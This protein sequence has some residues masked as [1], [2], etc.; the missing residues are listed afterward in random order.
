MERAGPAR[1]TGETAAFR[2][3]RQLVGWIAGPGLGLRGQLDVPKEQ[4]Y[5]LRFATA[6][7]PLDFARMLIWLFFPGPGGM[8]EHYALRGHF[9]SGPACLWHPCVGDGKRPRQ[10]GRRA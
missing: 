5:L 8:R 7:S 6:E 1:N 3:R 9:A 10:P 4:G 2:L